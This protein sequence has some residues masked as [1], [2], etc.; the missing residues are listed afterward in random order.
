MR[1]DFTTSVDSRQVMQALG[2]ATKR[3]LISSG[4]AMKEV[5]KQ[6]ASELKSEYKTKAQPGNDTKVG[7]TKKAIGSKAVVYPEGG[8]IALAGVRKNV[9]KAN[10][11]AGAWSKKSKN[12]KTVTRKPKNIWRLIESGTVPRRINRGSRRN[13]ASTG[14]MPAFNNAARVHARVSNIVLRAYLNKIAR[15]IGRV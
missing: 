11:W 10:V 2:K 9:E 6:V 12:G 15:S 8:A 7:I 13:G 3:L 4:D 5:G 14:S 1:F